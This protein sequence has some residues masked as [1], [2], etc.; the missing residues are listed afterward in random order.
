MRSLDRS[1]SL[2]R[3]NTTTL[4]PSLRTNRRR[5]RQR[6]LHRPVVDSIPAFCERTGESGRQQCG[7]APDQ[8]LVRSALCKPVTA[9]CRATSDEEQAVS[10][11]TAGPTR[12]K[13]KE[14]RPLVALYEVLVA[15]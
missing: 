2:S 7:Y 10:T 4:Q 8:R 6:L 1:T 3:F 13:A 9:W 5:I 11:A 15:V 12:L 14:T